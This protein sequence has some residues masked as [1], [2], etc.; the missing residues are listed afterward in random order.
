MNN[1]IFIS[2]PSEES[3]RETGVYDWPI[4]TCEV[5]QFPWEYSDQE[6]C[7]I[8]EGEIEVK[9]EVET[10]NIKPGDFVVFP[11]GLTCTWIVTSPVKK[12]YSF[13]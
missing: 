11:K 13:T 4:W 3:L 7:L 1:K 9:T 5:S 12:H 8:L 10:V 2:R 6:S